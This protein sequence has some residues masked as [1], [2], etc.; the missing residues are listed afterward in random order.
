VK[1][2]KSKFLLLRN[3]II[4]DRFLSYITD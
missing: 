1:K 4:L 3:F 2:R